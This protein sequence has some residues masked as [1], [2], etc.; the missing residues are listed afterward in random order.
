MVEGADK[1]EDGYRAVRGWSENIS[2]VLV[3]V[4]FMHFRNESEPL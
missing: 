1:F 2:D 3:N 4:V